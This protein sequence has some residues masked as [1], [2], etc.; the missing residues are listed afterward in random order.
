MLKN[1]SIISYYINL[2]SNGVIIVSFLFFVYTLFLQILNSIKTKNF[3]LG[4]F[5]GI[6]ILSVLQVFIMQG[7][8]SDRF[9]PQVF[10]LT[11]L[12]HFLIFFFIFKISNKIWRNVITIVYSLFWFIYSLTERYVILFKGKPYFLSDLENADTA[13]SVAGNYSYTPNKSMIISFCLFLVFIFI[14][15]TCDFK[16][17]SK[18]KNFL[19][20]ILAVIYF[21]FI[22]YLPTNSLLFGDIFDN[23]MYQELTMAMNNGYLGNLYVDLSSFNLKMPKDYNEEVLENAIEKAEDVSPYKSNTKAINIICVLEESFYDFSIISDLNLNKDYLEFFHSQKEED[24]NNT[25]KGYTVVS[26]YGGG[27]PNSE[28]EFLVGGNLMFFEQNSYP[29][30]KYIE[31]KCPSIA[32]FY[33]NNDFETVV[34]HPYFKNNW[35]RDRAYPLLGFDSYIAGEDI[36][37]YIN[38]DGNKLRGILTDEADFNYIKKLIDK[39]DSDKIFVYNVTIQNHSGYEEGFGDNEIT[40]SNYNLDYFNNYLNLAKKSDRS[41]KDLCKYVD[42]LEEPTLLLVFGDHIPGTLE[43]VFSKT[44]DF[45]PASEEKLQFYRTP[46]I[47]HTNYDIEEDFIENISLSYLSN[48]VV[49]LSGYEK[50]QEQKLLSQ[51]MLKYPII[52]KY[53]YVDEDGNYFEAKDLNSELKIWRDLTYKQ[54]LDEN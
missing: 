30:A 18:K 1:F 51:Y 9:L 33:K 27:T 34:F 32:S 3:Y 53:E 26:A 45:L 41:I 37:D 54:L 29:L 47:L 22:I 24:L 35:H 38:T 44:P 16:E 7:T 8:D 43:K 39:K 50:T 46:F 4:T 21:A 2:I 13:I 15:I 40:E 11:F 5:T 48:L 28:Y 23:R 17:N 25:I 49:G 12:F 10:C 52:H 31:R 19:G 6:S 20:Y 14:L 42:S 36:L